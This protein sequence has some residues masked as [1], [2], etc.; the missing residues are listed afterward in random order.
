[1]R[2]TIL[3]ATL[4]LL[5]TLPLADAQQAGV[6]EATW[7]L[8]VLGRI[9][10]DSRNVVVPVDKFQLEGFEVDNVSEYRSPSVTRKG[11]DAR[12]TVTAAKA[13]TFYPGII[14]YD[15]RG[16]ER[17]ELRVAGVVRGT[18]IADADDN[19]ERLYFTAEPVAFR[20]GETIELR[21]LTADGIYRT[22]N[23]VLL[24]ERPAPKRREFTIT[25][26][27]PR[28]EATARSATAAITWITSWP[29]ACTVEWGENK[30][31]VEELAVNNH[32]VRLADLEPEQSYRFRIV[33][34]TPEGGEVTST[35]REFR[36]EPTLAPAG[37][38]TQAR[39]LLTAASPSGAVAAGGLLPVTAG[40]PFPEG[41]LGS[42]ENLRVL[43][44]AGR[45]LP[46][47]SRMQARWKDGSV[48][49]V[50]LDFQ[51]RPDTAY[52]LEYGSDVR[53]RQ[54]LSRLSVKDEPEQVEVVTG[55]LRIRV[56]KQKYGVPGSVWFDTSGN[57]RFEPNEAIL[58]PGTL[59]LRD[60]SGAL[61]SSFAPPEEVVVEESGPVRAVVRVSGGHY[62]EDGRRLFR[63]I[64]RLHA[65]AGLPFVRVEHTFENDSSAAEFTSIR[66]L[67]LRLPLTPAGA[68]KIEGQLG[69]TG[70]ALTAPVHLAQHRDDWYDISQGRRLADGRRSAGLARWS[71]GSR[72]VQL[73]MRDFWQNYPKDLT[74]SANGFE[75]GICPPLA[76]NEY[77]DAKGTMDEHRLYYYLQGGVYKFRQGVSK[78]HDLWLSFGRAAE[79]QAPPTSPLRTVAPA[80]WYEAGKAFGEISVPKQNGILARY[81]EAF[82][83]SFDGY[84][85]NRET[86]R[87]YGMLN[88][89]DWWGERVINWG[90]SE[91][92]TQHAFFLQFVRTGDWRPFLAGE[93]ME[94][95]NR[96]VD[97]IHHHSDKSRV[98]GVYLHCVGHTG[99]YYST[100]PF[101]GKGITRG[102]TIIS[103][104]FIEG[105]LDYYFLTGDRRSLDTAMRIAD[106]VN[107]YETRNYDFTNCRNPGW[108]LVLNMAAYNATNDPFYLNAARIIVERVL[109][110]Q[111]RNGGWER[112]MV[113]GHC[114]CTPHH[115]GNAGFMVGV[116]LTGLK[117]YY[118]A[119][120]D[121]LVATS[122]VRG[123][124]FLI[125]DMW[126]PEVNGFRYTSCPRSNKGAWSNFLLF[127]GIAFAHRRTHDAK[128]GE[129]LQRGTIPALDTMNSMGKG[130]TQYTRVAPHFIGYLADLQEAE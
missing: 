20:G 50:L 47:Q 103:H 29:A 23:I 7:G 120:A 114:T 72:S 96:D 97:T 69:G 93:E 31:H 43:D 121:E 82:A 25:Q 83:R 64:T 9:L 92:D 49:W 56:S 77:D 76:A 130:F 123:S 1:M 95:H 27:E 86:N 24:A 39:V 105:H 15:S 46:L 74:V 62:A 35:W 5:A 53:R 48:K 42:D 68:G 4:S 37:S 10:G 81:D 79:A 18:V 11:E 45:E 125:D 115:R 28:S 44:Q 80:A 113:P 21:A 73:A 54:G 107:T 52:T 94:W 41:A 129:I 8:D 61:F 84:L 16:N 85:G 127:D 109:E 112:Q 71:D 91:Y 65:Y 110:R 33:A 88:F 116:L 55:P 58:A 128:L 6:M 108:H 99:D 60:A 119:T 124:H 100:S 40:V 57:G 70:A 78:T 75:L 63:F 117:H 59:E 12:I 3:L 104:T 38:V 89:G 32:R 34:R 90:N 36:T 14:F 106:R 122:I 51:G 126:E 111:T 87:E 102:G 17:I 101:E 2:L 66:S 30:R 22:E 98:G 13:G 67:V 26:V 19:R 118:D